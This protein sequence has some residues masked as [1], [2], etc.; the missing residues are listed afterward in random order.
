VGPSG[1]LAHWWRELIGVTPDEIPVGH[2]AGRHLNYPY[3]ATIYVE[4]AHK[5]VA[6]AETGVAMHYFNVV[7][8]CP[9]QRIACTAILIMNVACTSPVID[10]ASPVT[11]VAAS[12]HVN[13]LP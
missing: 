10:V 9:G 5:Q 6:G 1:P 11:D 12:I 7:G 8:I 2:S 3:Y 4:S 13:V